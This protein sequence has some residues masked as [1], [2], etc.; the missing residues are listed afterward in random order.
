MAEK[1]KHEN[2]CRGYG[3]LRTK[4]FQGIGVYEI[5]D[6]C[7]KVLDWID[8]VEMNTKEEFAHNQK[9][10]KKLEEE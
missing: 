10:L 7:Y 6:D 1:C 5:C 9:M 8:D 2:T 4:G 3:F